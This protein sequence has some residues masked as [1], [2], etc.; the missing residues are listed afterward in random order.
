MPGLDTFAH[1]NLISLNKFS[2]VTEGALLSFPLFSVKNNVS[3]RVIPIKQDFIMMKYE[4]VRVIP[5][6]QEM[7]VAC[8]LFFNK[9][10][11][12][13]LLFENS[14][15]T[16]LSTTTGVRKKITKKKKKRIICW[17]PV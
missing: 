14:R 2:N 1:M 4:P 3:V 11:C 7:T 9:L 8:G 13:R 15:V 17:R 5:P 6:R 12:I 10:L 16:E